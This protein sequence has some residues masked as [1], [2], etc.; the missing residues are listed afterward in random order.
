MGMMQ[1][2]Y[3]YTTDQ[4]RFY[5]VNNTAYS[6]DDDQ[7]KYVIA[8]HHWYPYPDL[9]LGTAAFWRQGRYLYPCERV[10][11]PVLYIE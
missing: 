8:D 7:P 9:E 10:G 2:A 1:R 3:D 11:P 4:A 6:T 5:I